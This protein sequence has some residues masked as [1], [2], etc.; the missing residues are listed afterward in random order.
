MNLPSNFTETLLSR[1]DEELYEMLAHETDYLPEALEAARG[2]LGRR[3]LPVERQ[4]HLQA[5]TEPKVADE[6]SKWPRRIL[7][8]LGV[9]AVVGLALLSLGVTNVMLILELNIYEFIAATIFILAYFGTRI[10]NRSASSHLSY[11]A[12]FSALNVLLNPQA[13]HWILMHLHF[14]YTVGLGDSEFRS[15]AA[16]I[17]SLVSSVVALVRIRR[18]HG[19][20]RGLP[21]AIFGIAGGVLWAGLWMVVVLM[22]ARGMANFR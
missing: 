9:C 5:V 21:L 17:V 20:L 3:N 8:L 2:E 13:I 6:A 11:L 15:F 7:I 18:S 19:L 1:T 10:L 16:G 22:F 14:P 12:I 4:H